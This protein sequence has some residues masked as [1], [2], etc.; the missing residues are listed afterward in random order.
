MI[1]NAMLAASANRPFPQP[2][3]F[4]SADIHPLPSPEIEMQNRAFQST[5]IWAEVLF[6]REGEAWT[7]MDW[8]AGKAE[9]T[10]ADSG[11]AER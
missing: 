3:D 10:S 7:P 9:T 4:K 1:V 8:S 5:A 2:P 6:Y 11:D